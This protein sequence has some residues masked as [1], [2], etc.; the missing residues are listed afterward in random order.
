MKHSRILILA[1]VIV[2]AAAAALFFFNTQ[3]QGPL[4]S[5]AAASEV[6]TLVPVKQD[7]MLIT[8][9]AE[10][11]VDY[12]YMEAALEKQFPDVDFV[13][14]LHWTGD[15]PYELRQSL[16]GGAAEDIVLSAFMPAVDDVAPK[17]LLDLSAKDFTAHYKT[18]AL[19]E[20]QLGGRLY[21]LPGPSDMFS[22]ICNRTMFAKYGWTPPKSRTEFNELCKKISAANLRALQPTCKNAPDAQLL[23]TSFVYK[24]LFAGLDNY[25]WLADYQ[26]GRA[27][28]SQHLKPAFDNFKEM[29]ALDLVRSA[30]FD[31]R[32]ANRS[33]MEYTDEKCAMIIETQMAQQYAQLYKSKSEYAMMPFWNGDAENDDYL[34]TKRN[35]FLGVNKALEA[36]E[37]AKKLAKVMEVV[38]Y[39]STPAGQR[40][41]S[42][43]TL[44]ML[45]CIK[46]AAIDFDSF[47][48]GVRSTIKKEN[49]AQTVD[50][51]ASGANN[52]VQTTLHDGLRDF[53]EGK[54]S[55]GTVMNACDAARDKAL[56]EGIAKGAV[57]GRAQENFTKLETGLFIAD[58]FKKKTGADVGLCMVGKI[59][60]GT[61]ARIYKGDITEKD[62]SMLTMML[63]K[64]PQYPDDKKLGVVSMTGAQLM[65]L[66]RRP[67]EE[68]DSESF[69]NAPYFVAAGL[70]I[71]FAP[72][73]P[74]DR[75]L[76]SVTM[77]D[78]S[79]LDLHKLYKV[80]LWYWP[81]D[82]RCPYKTVRIYDESCDDIFKEALKK[83]G[84]VTPIRDGR[85]ALD[86]SR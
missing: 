47:N 32:R 1:A 59:N 24:K 17:Y 76:K 12:D 14:V 8:L 72:W 38:A 29:A 21:Y 30:D 45:P 51:L 73:A 39:I 15:T 11:D 49:F 33:K 18:S 54:S 75:K 31:I 28:M 44:S 16:A 53:L 55:A 81:F 83:A 27:K 71:V 62:V 43:G 84:A 60:Y 57:V 65:A 3:D 37:N 52:P 61:V 85:F 42:G 50:F 41:C 80:A 20:C 79:P 5:G 34:V 58:A 25:K 64:K 63:E 78:D 9:R 23:F 40:A 6:L 10:Y 19:N 46:G 4:P 2:C 26:Q 36:P 67:Y 70:K 48:E 82:A 7:K 56:R 74:D 69:R 22:L 13:F 77:A 66:L 86:W 35:Y 68:K